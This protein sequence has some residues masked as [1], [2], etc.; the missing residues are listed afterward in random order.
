MGMEGVFSGGADIAEFSDPAA[1]LVEDVDRWWPRAMSAN[2][3]TRP[4]PHAPR[5]ADAPMLPDVLSRIETFPKTCVAA[6]RGYALGGLFRFTI[7]PHPA[8]Q[9]MMIS[10]ADSLLWARQ[11]DSSLR[12]PATIASS[13]QRREW[14][15]PRCRLACCRAPAV[16]SAS[17]ALL[18]CLES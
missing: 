18:V 4:R 17:R 13:T 7:H 14:G 16:P 5:A 10:A 2:T 3:L 1:G 11:A 12:W 9:T 6:I 15:C 8:P